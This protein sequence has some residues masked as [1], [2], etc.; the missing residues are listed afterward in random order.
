MVYFCMF[1]SVWTAKVRIQSF[2]VQSFSPFSSQRR[3]LT[4]TQLHTFWKWTEGAI[5]DGD[6]R[7]KVGTSGSI[8]ARVYPFAVKCPSCS[9]APSPIVPSSTYPSIHSSR[10]V[11]FRT[12]VSSSFPFH[13]LFLSLVLAVTH[14]LTTSHLY[15]PVH[16]SLSP[17]PIC[18]LYMVFI[19]L[20]GRRG[21]GRER[22][23]RS[24]LNI[25][26]VC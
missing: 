25:E 16:P 26:A 18:D 9:H 6:N 14:F 23:E 12:S 7:D 15:I 4:R 21:R 3:C 13:S 5:H 11:L 2:R 20:S 10:P 24:G 19:V 22:E 8:M 17:S 1:V